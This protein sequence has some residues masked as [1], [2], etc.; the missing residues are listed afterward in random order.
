MI[1]IGYLCKNHIQER[2]SSIFIWNNG[3]LYPNMR[4]YSLYQELKD[5]PLHGN[6]KEVYWEWQK[7]H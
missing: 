7:H 5:V 3:L 4:Y 1:I 2:A 6:H